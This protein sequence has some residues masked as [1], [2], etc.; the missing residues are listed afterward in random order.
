VKLGR[1]I[2]AQFRLAAYLRRYPEKH[3]FIPQMKKKLNQYKGP[4]DPSQIAAGINAAKRNAKRLY[5]DAKNLLD[6]KR[7][8]SAASLAVLSIEESGKVYILRAFS[9]ARDEKERNETWREYR[10]HTKKN[11]SWILPQLV[12]KG[13]RKLDDFKPIFD[14]GSDHPYILDQIKQLGFY[15]DCLGKAHWS[16][17][18][19]VV[20]EQLA[21]LLVKISGIFLQE[22]E[23]SQKEIELWIKHIGPVWKRN[24][25]W[26]KKALANWWAEMKE[27]G[28]A[29]E[30][31][32]E[33]EQ[34]IY[35][36]ISTE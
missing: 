26:M 3:F 2:A 4:L 27:N 17:P 12:A 34:F 16:L 36:G 19:E 18:D 32:S 8:P 9:V 5:E 13:A 30:G 15:T 31:D 11:V 21:T 6:C 10:S 22:K 28:L 20:D 23:T 35:Q 29:P 14:E 7:Y 24:L 1:R 25:T 33:F